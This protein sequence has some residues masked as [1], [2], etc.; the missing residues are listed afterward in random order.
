MA[1]WSGPS[2]VSGLSHEEPCLAAAMASG[3]VAILDV[4]DALRSRGNNAAIGETAAATA[5]VARPRAARPIRVL[6]AQVE[7]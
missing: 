1:L 6:Q 5:T 3:A 7:F 4:A 2:A